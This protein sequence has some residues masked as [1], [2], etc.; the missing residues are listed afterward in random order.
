[1]KKLLTEILKTLEDSFIMASESIKDAYRDFD[2]FI[3]RSF[4]SKPRGISTIASVRYQVVNYVPNE[5]DA[6]TIQTYDDD[7]NLM[8]DI[9]VDLVPYENVHRHLG[10]R[11]WFNIYFQ[12]ILECEK[13]A[14]E[15]RKNK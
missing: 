2:S 6:V 9:R 12:T 5:D 3:E 1:M 7:G 11:E 8:K 14:F 13:Q 15:S 10:N 4:S